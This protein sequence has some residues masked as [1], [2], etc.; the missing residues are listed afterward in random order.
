M[1]DFDQFDHTPAKEFWRGARCCEFA[2][3]RERD[4]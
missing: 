4:F 2:Q 3:Q 1:A